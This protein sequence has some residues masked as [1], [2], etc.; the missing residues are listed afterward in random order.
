MKAMYLYH[1]D[2]RLSV[3][4]VHQGL[5]KI[6]CV[7]EVCGCGKKTTTYGPDDCPEGFNQMLYELVE[8]KRGQGFTEEEP[9]SEYRAAALRLGETIRAEEE[10]HRVLG[11]VTVTNLSSASAWF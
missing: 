5:K 6:I 3:F 10:R 9:T 8:S 7:E 1:P 2:G 4:T 11:T